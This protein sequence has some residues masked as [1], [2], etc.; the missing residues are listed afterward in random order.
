MIT[1]PWMV[2]CVEA[3]VEDIQ[4]FQKHLLKLQGMLR[5]LL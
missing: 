5:L 4:F 2:Q 3:M 1:P